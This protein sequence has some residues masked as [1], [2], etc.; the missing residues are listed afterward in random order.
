MYYTV[1]DAAKILG[2]SSRTL[3]R[4]IAAGKVTVHRLT[5]KTVRIKDTDLDAFLDGTRAQQ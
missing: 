5:P 2:V 3:S 1:K 4:Y